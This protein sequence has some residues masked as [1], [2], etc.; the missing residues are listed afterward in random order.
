MRAANREIGRAITERHRYDDEAR[1]AIDRSH[2]AMVGLQALTVQHVLAMRELL[3][4]DQRR[5]FDST[6]DKALADSGP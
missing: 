6:V 4:P 2:Q 3:T 5:Q 1:A